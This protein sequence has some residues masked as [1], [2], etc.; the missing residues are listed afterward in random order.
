[1]PAKLSAKQRHRRDLELTVPQCCG[2]VG[3]G[4]CDGRLQADHVLK[5][6]WMRWAE[7]DRDELV[8]DARNGWWLC[9][10]HHMLKDRKLL[11]PPLRRQDLPRTVEEFAAEFKLEPIIERHFAQ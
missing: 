6:Q 7:G 8:A 2:L 4:S 3:R 11:R 9:E 5:V 10:W 1:M